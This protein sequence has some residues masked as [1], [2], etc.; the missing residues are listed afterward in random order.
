[1]RHRDGALVRALGVAAHAADDPLRERNPD[2][3]VV[4]EFRMPLQRRHCGLARGCVTRR[5]EGEPVALAEPPVPLRPELW[6]GPDEREVDVEEDGAKRHP[7]SH[8]TASTCG[9]TRSRPADHATVCATV[10]PSARS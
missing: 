6:T 1:A 7:S 9:A 3:V 4:L 2:L 5:V 8:P 10:Q